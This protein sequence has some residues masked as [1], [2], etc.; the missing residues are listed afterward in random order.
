MRECTGSALIKDDLRTS[1]SLWG[2]QGANMELQNGRSNG[3]VLR[4]VVRGVHDEGD[5]D[6]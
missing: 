2:D 1:W 4:C 6:S 3:M 5:E